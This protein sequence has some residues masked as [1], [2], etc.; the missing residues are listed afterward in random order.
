MLGGAHIHRSRLF[1]ALVA[2][3][4]LG[5]VASST[6]SAAVAPAAPGYTSGRYLV[7]FADEPVASYTGYAKGFAATQPRAG[8]KLNATSTAALAWQAHLVAK[9][10]A[11]LAK[12]GATKPGRCAIR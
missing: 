12:V 1:G 8:H 10:D 5:L 11:A 9:H 6:V 7:T 3:A 4:M 2:A